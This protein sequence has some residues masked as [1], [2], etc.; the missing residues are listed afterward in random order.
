MSLC[1]KERIKE[2]R[3]W[4]KQQNLPGGKPVVRA[5]RKHFGVERICAI[6]DL[7]KIGGLD[8]ETRDYCTGQLQV[9]EER[10]A[11]K[12]ERKA[13]SREEC[14][15]KDWQDGNFFFIAGYTF[16]GAP[17]GITWEEE[18]RMEAEEEP[19]FLDD[20]GYLAYL[21]S[22]AEEVSDDTDLPFL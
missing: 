19:D 15:I 1:R 20:P 22:M 7:L 8:P 3:R 14:P 2:G 17:Y 16:G 5:Y 13:L 9:R 21:E 11:L 10:N 4:L 12:R 6:R 18:R